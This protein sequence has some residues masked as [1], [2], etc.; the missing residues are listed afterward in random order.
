MA[1]EI[2]ITIKDHQDALKKK[3][4]EYRPFCLDFLD[5]IVKELVDMAVNEFQGDKQDYDLTIRSTLR[6]EK[7][8]R[9]KGQ[10]SEPT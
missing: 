1:V 10:P 8:R 6:N 7:V 4:V 3:F 5:P 2:T 9:K